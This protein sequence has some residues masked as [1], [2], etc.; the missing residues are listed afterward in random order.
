[1]ERHSQG[2]LVGVRWLSRR[3]YT[4]FRLFVAQPGACV[5]FKTVLVAVMLTLI[6]MLAINAKAEARTHR[7]KHHFQRVADHSGSHRI[8]RTVGDRLRLSEPRAR[9]MRRLTEADANGSD[10]R[11]SAWCGWWMRK[12]LGVVSTAF[13]LAREWARFGSPASGPAVG[14]IVVWP[15]HVGIITG[16]SGDRWVVK[17][18]NDGHAVRERPRSVSG[19]IAFRWPRYQVAGVRA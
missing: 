16:K 1:M 11:P 4:N 12:Q 17:S 14:T 13:N 5:M 3:I 2:I 10:A 19:A 15:H 6:F 8:K 7:H 18:G 9:S